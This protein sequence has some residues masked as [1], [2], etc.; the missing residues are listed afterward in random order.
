[1]KESAGILLYRHSRR[2]VEV[3][4]AHPGGP[5]F[6]N[7]SVGAWTIPKGLI[8]RGESAEVAAR[9]EFVEETGFA[10]PDTLFELGSVRLR[11]GK[12]IYAFAGEGE[13]DPG[14]LDSN[15]FD[16]EW[17]RKSG[18]VRSYPELDQVRYAQPNEARELL[19]PAQSLLVDRLLAYLG[20]G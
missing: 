4:I 16:L 2:S 12:V 19:N 10:P 7:R 18:R 17:P 8:E 5:F 15:R 1:M 13:V 11:S 3:L 6:A 14:A 9:R 20:S